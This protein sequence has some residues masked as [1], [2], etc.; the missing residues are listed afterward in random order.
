VYGIPP[1][2]K[3]LGFLPVIFVKQ[4]DYDLRPVYRWPFRA[5]LYI[6]INS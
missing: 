4:G 5:L 1:R 6:F 2:D 3:S